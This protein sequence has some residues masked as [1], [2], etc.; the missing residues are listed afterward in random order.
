MFILES[1]EDSGI[2]VSFCEQIKDYEK[3]VIQRVSNA[4]KKEAK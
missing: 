2:L 1:Y 4:A 3:N